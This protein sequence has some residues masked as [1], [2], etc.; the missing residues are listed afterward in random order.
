MACVHL[1][2][3]RR[4]LPR[5]IDDEVFRY[6]ADELERLE[7]ALWSLGAEV[8]SLREQRESELT[9]LSCADTAGVVGENK[10]LA[11]IAHLKN[12]HLMDW[13]EYGYDHCQRGS[14]DWCQGYL[15]SAKAYIEALEAAIQSN[16][17][18]GDASPTLIKI[19]GLHNVIAD[20]DR[21][22]AGLVE[23]NNRLRSYLERIACFSQDDN[24]LWWQVQA[25]AALQR[26]AQGG[27]T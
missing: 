3:G 24:L 1:E 27:G 11:A 4:V 5:Y 26:D 12:T 2:T 22:I 10:R 20:R 23:E 7:T 8:L 6:A 21:E 9:R 25:R 14:K 19:D 13:L 16:K 15:N 17:A 18:E